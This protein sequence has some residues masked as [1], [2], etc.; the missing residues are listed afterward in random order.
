[1]LI[2][3]Q[4]TGNWVAWELSFHIRSGSLNGLLLRPV[5]PLWVSAVWMTAALPWRLAILAPMIGLLLAARPDTLLWPGAIALMLCAVA[6]ALAWLLA[7]LIQA[8]I[9]SLSFWIDKADGAFGVWFAVWSLAGGYL[10]PTAFYPDWMQ[11]TLRWLPLRGTLAVPVELLAGF[12]T[13]A[14]ALPEIGIQVMW[15]AVFGLVL[16]VVWRRGLVRY[17]AFGT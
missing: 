17:G 8:I 6:T 14:Q 16:R 3:R 4:L 5:H 1:V 9:G 12:L 13:P 2:L 11:T 10:A 15:C 7:F